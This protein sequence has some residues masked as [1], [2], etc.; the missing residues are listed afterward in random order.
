MSRSWLNKKAGLLLLLMSALAHASAWATPISVLNVNVN[1]TNYTAAVATNTGGTSNVLITCFRPGPAAPDE[2]ETVRLDL[3]KDGTALS[4]AI[5]P[6]SINS[7]VGNALCLAAGV[8]ITFFYA[9]TGLVLR[10]TSPNGTTDDSTSFTVN[11]SSPAR[12]IVLAP[13]MAHDPGKSPASLSTGRT[14]AAVTQD[15]KQAFSLTVILTDIA[16]NRVLTGPQHTVSFASGD[17]TV[18]PSPGTLSS[19]SGDF[20]VIINAAKTTRTFTV[21]DATDNSVLAGAVDVTTKGPPEEEVFPFP[22]PFNPGLGQS[23]KFRFHLNTPASVTLKVKD[24]FGQAVWESSVA[25]GA[26]F[27]D[28]AWDGKNENGATVAAGIYYVILE[29]GGSVKSK[30]RF[31]VTK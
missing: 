23:A 28:V 27:T 19:G 13:G 12:L 8:P 18:L 7:T 15:P 16:F 20:N 26:G 22:S 10:A 2:V 25:A 1:E 9:G 21:S 4:N 24:P 11:P 6:T 31:G 29:I 30:K 17:L 5:S 3:V 14:G